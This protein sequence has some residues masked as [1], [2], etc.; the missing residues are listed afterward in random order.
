MK[1]LVITYHFPPDGE[2]GG[3]RPYQLARHLPTFGV[4]PW[5]LTVE[6]RFAESLDP[7][8]G[9]PGVPE[10]RIVRT[11][12][13]GTARDGVLRL[14]RALKPAVSSA[15]RA[16][17]PQPPR[18]RGVR[19][20]VDSWLSFPDPRIGWYRP[21]LRVAEQVHRR[22]GFDA[23]LSTSPPRVAALVASRL[24]RRHQLPWVMDL[25]DPWQM[26]WEESTASA[27][28]RTLLA[29]LFRR[30]ARRAHR[31]VHN[32]ERLRLL[33]CRLVPEAAGKTL[34]IPN[35]VDPAWK[36]V[37]DDAA[38]S[39]F[40]IGYYGQIMGG[41][42]PEAF[43]EGL[44]L[45]LE[46]ARPDP[47]RV[48]V[49]FVGP[50]LESLATRVVSLGLARVVKV[51]PPVPRQAIAGLIADDYVLLLIANAQ[52]MQIP[53]KAYEYLATGRRILALADREGATADLLGP[54]PGCAVVEGAREVRGALDRW[55]GEFKRGVSPRVDRTALLGEMQYPRRVE[56]FAE[57]LHG[58]PLPR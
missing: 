20:W 26:S 44:G 2:I 53:G 17:P 47:D 31:I 30:C 49:R 56:R 23:L 58:I 14:W 6:P 43:L 15:S 32:T 35:G 55:F 22:V 8:L 18:R 11:T 36:P 10:D 1:V 42:S 48:V 13:D 5:V 38:P 29:R 3:V 41:R 24:S 12:V 40:G 27:M 7:G 54:L 50:G 4:D 39:V 19:D 21:A 46:T 51:L 52:P 25:R 45:W 16:Q 34:C 57:A 37:R 9:A 33:T 28:T